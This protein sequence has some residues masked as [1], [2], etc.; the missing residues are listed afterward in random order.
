MSDYLGM[1]EPTP[2][3]DGHLFTA[4][5][6]NTKIGMRY[7]LKSVAKVTPT[8]RPKLAWNT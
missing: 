4:R 3:F 5:R 2:L 7:V 6:W 1:S 8:T